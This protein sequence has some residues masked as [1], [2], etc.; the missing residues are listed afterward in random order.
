LK[1]YEAEADPNQ[2]DGILKAHRNFLRQAVYSLYVY[3]HIKD[4]AQWLKYLGEKYPDKLIID[5][6]MNSIPKNVTLDQYVV[7]CVQE[8][9]NDTGKDRM[10]TIL[11]GLMTTS[12][13][14]LVIDEDDRAAGLMQISRQAWQS[15]QGKIPQKR[16][17]SIG[18]LP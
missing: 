9:I 10:Q 5:G 12:Y 2:R 3:N 11:E 15:Y 8:D 7:A 18:L 17:S 4:A 16:T 1:M 13:A 14:S 6:D